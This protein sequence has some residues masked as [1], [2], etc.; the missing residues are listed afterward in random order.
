[1]ATLREAE[2]AREET[3]DELLRLG[4]HAISVEELTE[5]LDAETGAGAGG[6]GA[7]GTGAGGASSA[8]EPGNAAFA[9]TAAGEGARGTAG[10][11]RAGR[12]PVGEPGRERSSFAVVA[13]FADEP[14]ADLPRELMI[15]VGTRTKVVP[16]RARRAEGFRAE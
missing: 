1:M 16:L 2:R 15:K 3:A 11:S 14:P 7:G 6:A 13:W 8:A 10:G 9:A 4:A 12:E 5:T